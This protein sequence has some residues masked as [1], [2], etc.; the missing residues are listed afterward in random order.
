MRA[1]SWHRP[2]KARPYDT[3]GTGI[4]VTLAVSYGRMACAAGGIRPRGMRHDR[5]AATGKPGRGE[6]R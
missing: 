6:S 2:H 5:R 1:P 3:T 4:P